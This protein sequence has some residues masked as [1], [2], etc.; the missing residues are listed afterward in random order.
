[1]LAAIDILVFL[2]GIAGAILLIYKKKIG[3]LSFVIHSILWGILSY[4][5]GNYGAV[6]TCIVFIIVDLFGYYKWTKEE[7]K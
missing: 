2:F 4:A 5:N 7:E 3:F 1:M 6:L